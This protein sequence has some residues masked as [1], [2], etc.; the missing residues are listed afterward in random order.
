MAIT[1]LQQ[2]I[3]DMKSTP[4]D[5]VSDFPSKAARIN[6]EINIG[7]EASLRKGK[8]E[9]IKGDQGKNLAKQIKKGKGKKPKPSYT[10]LHQPKK[11]LL[12]ALN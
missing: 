10:Y 9:G 7:A 5:V 4:V 12:G 8:D 2:K 1:P 3:K 11:K 6:E